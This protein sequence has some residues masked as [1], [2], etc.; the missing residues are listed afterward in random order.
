MNAKKKGYLAHVK[1]GDRLPGEPLTVGVVLPL[2]DINELMAIV[3]YLA[4]LH[5]EERYLLNGPVNGE[6][7]LDPRQ[8]F[9][10]SLGDCTHGTETPTQAGAHDD[11]LHINLN[12]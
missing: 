9:A 10:I 8:V 5:P 4:Q 2:L 3:I 11:D 1:L 12:E 7:L 6:P